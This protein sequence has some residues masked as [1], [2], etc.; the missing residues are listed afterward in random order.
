MCFICLAFALHELFFFIF[1][2]EKKLIVGED[3]IEILFLDYFENFCIWWMNILIQL[4]M[5]NA[6][7]SQNVKTH[8]WSWHRKGEGH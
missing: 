5:G 8:R 4:H 7:V 2:Q 1:S 6:S 3:N